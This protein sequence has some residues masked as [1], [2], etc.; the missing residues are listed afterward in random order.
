MFKTIRIIS[1][2]TFVSLA[3]QPLFGTE[4]PSPSQLKIERA[5]VAAV[6]LVCLGAYVYTIVEQPR[7]RE[8]DRVSRVQ[9]GNRVLDILSDSR[10]GDTPSP[11]IMNTN[12]FRV[13]LSRIQ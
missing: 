1:L 6:A 4:T 11:A 5:I 2:C 12:N 9:N 10:I 3:I 13:R 8:M 7:R